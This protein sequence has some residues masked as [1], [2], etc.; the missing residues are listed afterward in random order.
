MLVARA[1]VE[2]DAVW[3]W[4]ERWSHEVEL[5]MERECAPRVANEQYLASNFVRAANESNYFG[6]LHRDG[7]SR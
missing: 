4:R 1:S 6:Y 7:S 3:R 2:R 5:E